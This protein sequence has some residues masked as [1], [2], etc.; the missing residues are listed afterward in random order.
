MRTVTALKRWSCDDKDLPPVSDI[1]AIHVYD[2]DNTLFAS[3]LPNRQIWTGQTMGQLSSPEVFINGGWWHD[4]SILAA[5]GEGVEKEEPRAWKGWWNEQIVQLVELTMQ[6]KDA[7]G[8]LLTGRSESGFAELIKRIV[9]SKNLDFNMVCLKPATGPSNQ[10]FRSTMEFKQ[11][12][13]KDIVHTYKDAEEI[14]VYEDRVKHTK[15]FRDFFFHLNSD[16]MAEQI[17]QTRKPLVAEVV[18]VLENATQLD[19]VTEVA[20]IQRMINAHNLLVRDG[21]APPGTIPLQIKKTV[22]YTGYMIPHSMT[23]RLTSLIKLPSGSD[24]DIRLLANSILITPK[25]AP[26]S[27]LDKV[28]GL[29]ARV[30]WK[31]TGVSCFENKLWAARVEP[32]PKT[33]KFYSE[34]PTPTIILALRNGGRPA[35]ATRIVN[36]QPVSEDQRYVFESVV[37]EKASLRIEEEI[38]NETEYEGYFPNKQHPKRPHSNENSPRHYQ[39]DFRPHNGRDDRRNFSTS[40]NYRGGNRERGRG[41]NRDASHGG[42]GRGRGGFSRGGPNGGRGRG[43]GGQSSYRSLDDVGDRTHGQPNYDDPNSFY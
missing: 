5:T 17:P 35:D 12:L 32:I 16:L 31:V 39:R 6:Q 27:I 1:K 38:R 43:R 26:K 21:K 7:L 34:N 25:P 24:G 14:R 8:V 15:G 41:G 36:W 11:E 20:A 23:D 9:R 19:P 40:S 13:L 22:F 18:Q 10:K 3:P 33:Q 37:G 2:F 30:K 29:G 28:G 42:R 4:S